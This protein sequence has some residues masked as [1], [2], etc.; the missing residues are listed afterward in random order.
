MNEVYRYIT[1]LSTYYYMEIFY[2]PDLYACSYN[3]GRD[4]SEMHYQKQFTWMRDGS[5]IQFEQVRIGE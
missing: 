3:V 2:S 5:I 1:F 4:I